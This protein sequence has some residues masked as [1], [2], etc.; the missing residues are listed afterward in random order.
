MRLAKIKK[1]KPITF[2][3]SRHS[4]ITFLAKQLPVATVQK[5]AQ[6]SS[7]ATTMRYVHIAG[8]DISDSLSQVNWHN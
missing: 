4:G 2:H 6:H 1:H 5:L 7:I 8:K 3:T